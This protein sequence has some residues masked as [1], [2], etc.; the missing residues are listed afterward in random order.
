MPVPRSVA[1]V[2]VG[3]EESVL[4]RVADVSS[5]LHHFVDVGVGMED[6]KVAE[7][8]VVEVKVA[9]VEVAEI[10]L[11]NLAI[12]VAAIFLFP[13]PSVK[14]DFIFRPTAAAAFTAD[15]SS[16]SASDEN[17]PGLIARWTARILSNSKSN[18]VVARGRKEPKAG[19]EEPEDNIVMAAG[20]EE[21]ED[22]MVMAPEENMVMAP[23][24]KI[25]S[26]SMREQHSNKL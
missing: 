12:E 14:E 4:P 7:V 17:I 26:P 21:P 2:G 10:E 23:E 16:L 9:E 8:E 25:V 18:P 11:A 6:V 5:V 24:E 19:R 20:R 13:N 3:V 15:R 1:D 22:D